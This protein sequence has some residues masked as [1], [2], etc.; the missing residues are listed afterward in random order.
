MQDTE[1]VR[2]ARE[3]FAKYQRWIERPDSSKVE[4]RS[5]KFAH[6]TMYTVMIWSKGLRTFVEWDE[7][8][9]YIEDTFPGYFEE[10]QMAYE[11]TYRGFLGT[12]V[13]QFH[14][15]ERAIEWSRQVGVYNRC[16]I[17]EIP[18]E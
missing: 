1:M 9:K 2:D 5:V 18:R 13:R 11:V 17:T 15:L 4:I 10:D 14:S 3:R 8:K 7:C 6:L 16:V 12:V